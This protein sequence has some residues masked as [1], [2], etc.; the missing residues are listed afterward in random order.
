MAF[1][2]DAAVRVVVS[3]FQTSGARRVPRICVS[4]FSHLVNWCS[5]R[6]TYFGRLERSV[7]V[8][9]VYSE[10]PP[11]DALQRLFW[12]IVVQWPLVKVRSMVV[13]SLV[14]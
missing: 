7:V 13:G 9:M 5:R 3:F 14:P 12:V 10:V 4:N 11:E 8:V 6:E 2:L 1:I